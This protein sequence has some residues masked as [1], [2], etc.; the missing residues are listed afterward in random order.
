V[1]PKKALVLIEKLG[2]QSIAELEYACKENR[3]LKLKGF[4]PKLQAKILEGLH[5]YNANRGLQK[6]SD[7]LDLVDQ[8]IVEFTAA[9]PG[10]PIQET[11]ALRRKLEI[12]SQ[13]D[14]LVELAHGDLE[15]E[16]QMRAATEVFRAQFLSHHSRC[17]PIVFHFASTDS[18]GYE[19][20]KTTATP[21]HW[22]ALGNPVPFRCA[23]EKEFYSHLG[24]PWIPPET[25][26]TGEEISLARAGGMEKLL[27]WNGVRGI[28]HNHTTRSDGAATL[29]QMVAGAEKEGYEYIGISDH[30]QTAFYAQGLKEENLL[31][32]EA[33]IRELQKKYPKIRIFWGI[34]SDILADGSL[35]YPPELLK[36]FDF[37]IASIHSRFQMDR[38]AM[39]DRILYAIRNPFT[40]FLGHPTG[41]L[42]LGRKGYEVDMEAIIAEAAR[43]NVAIEMN[44]NP[45][46]LDLDWRWG[47][48]MRKQRT[49][50]SINPDAHEVD[51]L[52]DTVYGIAM[53]RKAMIPVD[54]VVNSKSVSEVEKW[55]RRA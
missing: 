13:L 2:I 35:D 12:L 44:A 25:R 9:Y 52:K 45:V 8:L 20:A 17:L 26:E 7:V 24:L 23:N 3:L 39:T 21:E 54:Q 15:S 49:F 31:E 41:R 50:T 11:G 34:E 38:Q 29:E 51:G 28:F 4:G 33:E 48:E 19:W 1:G 6:W 46:R 18:F 36:R 10:V 22:R 43:C 32:Q 40:R 14:F 5:F 30:S 47:H 55:L 37:V 42:L 53:A 27:P 16:K